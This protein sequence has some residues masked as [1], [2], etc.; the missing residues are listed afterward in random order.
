MN[1]SKVL[2]NFKFV[3]ELLFCSKR[4]NTVVLK[5]IVELKYFASVYEM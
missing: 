1:V 2:Q 5:R 4:T 3:F